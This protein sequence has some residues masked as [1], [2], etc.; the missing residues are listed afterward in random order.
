MPIVPLGSFLRWPEVCDE[1]LVLETLPSMTKSPDLSMAS[2]NNF[3][4]VSTGSKLFTLGFF[5]ASLEY[6]IFGIKIRSKIANVV[7][8]TIRL[9]NINHMVGLRS[10]KITRG[11]L[12]NQTCAVVKIAIVT[13][14]LSAYSVDIL[15]HS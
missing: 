1:S 10:D 6:I 7:H 3:L 8:N 12:I 13:Q 9:R 4:F 11:R 2:S 14:E 15:R 5:N